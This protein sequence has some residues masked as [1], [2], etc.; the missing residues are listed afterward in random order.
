MAEGPIPPGSPEL[1]VVVHLAKLG[2]LL[3]VGRVSVEDAVLFDEAG[4]QADAL[5]GVLLAQAPD[6]V[7]CRIR[8]RQF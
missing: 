5:T 3:R 6:R 4:A 2:A 1:T 7:G 8:L